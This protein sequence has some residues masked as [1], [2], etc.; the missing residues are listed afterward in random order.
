MRVIPEPVPLKVRPSYYC[1]RA[2]ELTQG[3]LGDLD[4]PGVIV[5]ADLTALTEN[6]LPAHDHS[7]LD[8]VNTV[9]EPGAIALLSL[10]LAGL[11]LSR[12]RK[13]H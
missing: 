11:G 9:P 6:N 1:K 7:L 8:T 10:A 5:G 2:R 12:R 13:L 3:R 4:V